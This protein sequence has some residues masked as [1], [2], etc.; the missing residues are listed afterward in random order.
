MIQ[1]QQF[2][3]EGLGTGASVLTMT[4]VAFQFNNVYL[5]IKIND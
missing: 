4:K 5:E 3:L 2:I 1:T